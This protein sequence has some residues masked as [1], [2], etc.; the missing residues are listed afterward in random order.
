M[1]TQHPH[2]Y[3]EHFSAHVVGPVQHR[4][5]DGQLEAIPSNLDV[6][7]ATA[8]ASFVLSWH[9]EGQPVTVTLSKPDFEYHV[10]NGNI[11]LK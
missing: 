11:I 4:I 10:D 1:T 8:I 9:S 7:V 3:P 6:A 2:T 5:G